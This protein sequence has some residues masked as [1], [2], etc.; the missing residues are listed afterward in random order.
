MNYAV[1]LSGGTGSRLKQIGIPKQYYEVKGKPIIR[2]AV[3]TI[4]ESRVIDA[5]VIIA[6]QEWHTF[7]KDKLCGLK[8]KF[9]G[10]AM[11]GENRQLSIYNGLEK[12][13]GT[14]EDNDVILIHDA[15]RPC[16][17]KQLICNCIKACVE[18]DGA[19]P[20]LPMKDTIYLSEDGKSVDSLLDRTKLFAGQAPEAFIYGKYLLANERLLRDKIVKINGSTEPAILAG[21]KIAMI[22]GEESNFKITTV[23]DLERFKSILE[24]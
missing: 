6:S 3:E 12:L 11:P 7:I 17:S 5:Y 10:F 19:M 15:A 9:A 8:G 21:L 20:V 2:Y 24:V 14:A 13:K 4:V 23:E 18:S 1:I 22:D 16:V